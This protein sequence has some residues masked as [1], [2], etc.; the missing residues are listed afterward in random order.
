MRVL[1]SAALCAC[2]LFLPALALGQ[3]DSPAP[4]PQNDLTLSTGWNGSWFELEDAYDQ[5]H[6]GLFGGLSFGHYWTDNLKTE[7]EAGW[8][9]TAK[10]RSFETISIGANRAYV[11]SDYLF[12]DLRV[13]LS[14]SVQ[15]GRNAWIHPFLGAGADIT[16][17]RTTE[18][19]APQFATVIV[20]SP[21]FGPSSQVF[22][23]GEKEDEAGVKVIPFVKGG[24]KIYMTDRTYIVQEFKFGLGHHLEHALWKTGIGFDF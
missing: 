10:T 23:P 2:C 9:S 21:P 24:F 20:T 8:V 17:R 11:N 13:S 15:F 18:D 16:Y 19:R 4:L 7:A 1:F 3:T 22:V 6:S 12:R 5:W 14:Q